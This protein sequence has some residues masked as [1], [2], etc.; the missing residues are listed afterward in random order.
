MATRDA[1]DVHQL[2]ND[3]SALCVHGGRDLPPGL[4]LCGLV[5]P[6]GTWIALTI[7]RGLHALADDET[8]ARTL[9]VVLD[10]QRG[11]AVVGIGA[12]A[13]HWRHHN[14]V[15]TVDIA[16]I[17]GRKQRSAGVLRVAHT[18]H[19]VASAP[20]SSS[21]VFPVIHDDAGVAR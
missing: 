19:T 9:R 18:G 10:M 3:P 12:T 5:Q 20:P 1:A 16:E 11:G 21:R 7:D 2:G 8:R 13:R 6:G 17:D 15:T 4:D 14:A